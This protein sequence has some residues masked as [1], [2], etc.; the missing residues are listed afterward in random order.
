MAVPAR[1]LFQALRKILA[2]T[3]FRRGVVF[4]FQIQPLAPRSTDIELYETRSE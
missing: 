3:Y 4:N 2:D 1:L